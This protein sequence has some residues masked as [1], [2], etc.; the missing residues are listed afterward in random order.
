MCVEHRRTARDGDGPHTVGPT[1]D[2]MADRISS[3]L[4]PKESDSLPNKGA[5]PNMMAAPT[6][7]KGTRD[8]M[9]AIG[10]HPPTNQPNRHHDGSVA[11]AMHGMGQVQ[12]GESNTTT[13]TTTMCAY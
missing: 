7:V 3:G 8:H 10:T 13:T 12:K 1:K 6:P 5:Q 9:R 4:R 2:M 11:E